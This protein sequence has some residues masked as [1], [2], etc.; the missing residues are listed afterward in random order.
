MTH[1][2]FLVL[3]APF[4]F[5]L[6][7]LGYC[8]PKKQ[9]PDAASARVKGEYELDI[10]RLNNA[11]ARLKSVVAA[12]AP[13]GE[14]QRAFYDARLTYKKVEYLAEYFNPY[15]AK[16]MNGPPVDEVE[17]DDPNQIVVKPT[18]FQVVEELLFPE[19]DAANR[20]EAL[21]EIGILHSSVNRLRLVTQTTPMAD[22]HIFDAMRQQVYRVI[23][24]GITGFDSPV[25][26]Y[27]LAEAAAAL[28]SLKQTFLVYQPDL[29]QKSPELA[30]RAVKAFDES[31]DFLQQ[32]T[33]FDRFDR[34][35]FI[36]DYAN[37]LSSTLA[38]AGEALDIPVPAGVRAVAAGARTLFDKDAFDPDYYAPDHDAH[39]TAARAGLGKMLFFDPI[40]SGNNSRSCASCHNPE[41]AFTDGQTK[42]I[43]FDFKGQVSRNSPTILNAALQRSLFHDMRVVFLEDQAS[44]VLAN[45]QEMHGSFG[46][47]AALV[48]Q[49]PEYL[50]M[51]R[52]AFPE[53]A[54]Q[55]APDA[56]TEQQMKVAIASYVRS[57]T[58]MDSRFDQYMRGDKTQLSAIEKDGLNLFTGK[59]KCATCHFL[60]LFNG[61]VPPTF[62]HTEAEII[63]V[64]SSADTLR[65][66][67]DPDLGRYHSFRI[68]LHR[69][70]FKTPT[71]RNVALTAPYMHNGVYNTLEEVVDF[72]NKGGGAGMG[73]SVP[74]QTLPAEPLH[75]TIGEKQALIAFMGALTDTSAVGSRPDKLPTFPARTALNNRLVGGRY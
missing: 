30:A 20:E 59:A 68:D 32:N 21:K 51:F 18:G 45:E 6:L 3:V 34:A 35:V 58:A 54:G 47:A 8:V 49:S 22:R 46:K 5:F 44:D 38:D 75:L 37:T 55:A 2:L 74:N 71:L 61:T 12:N 27:S 65:P 42:S 4:L 69:F 67:L 9:E 56:V 64:P 48:A 7:A 31:I 10:S 17:E 70:A 15:T 52:N 53:G 19:Y 14:I 29:S 28:S 60:P 43:A 62:D 50:D 36:A 23:T 73:I 40:L 33:G 25:A 1:K 11:L 24:L 66:V 63:G 72:Y 13:A 39:L 41:K 16:A 57:L 26:G